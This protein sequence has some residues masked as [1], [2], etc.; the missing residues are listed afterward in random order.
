MLTDLY[1]KNIPEETNKSAAFS[2]CQKITGITDLKHKLCLC[3][4]VVYLQTLGITLYYRYICVCTLV[5]QV[6]IKNTDMN[7][8]IGSLQS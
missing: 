2:P 5:R 1:E 8:P 7:L 6:M 3:I 4:I